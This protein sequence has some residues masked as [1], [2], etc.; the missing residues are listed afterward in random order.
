[1]DIYFTED[2]RRNARA[3]VLEELF[4]QTFEEGNSNVTDAFF[5]NVPYDKEKYET[6]KNLL[7]DNIPYIDSLIAK[8]AKERPISDI[9]GIDLNILRIVIAEG[10]IG[11]ITPPKVAINEAVELAKAFGAES[12]YKFINGVLGAL[13]ASEFADLETNEQPSTGA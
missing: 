2:P 4:A 13:Y 11:K 10:F 5:E 3:L 6:I 1:M 8:Y 7:K 12:S 9:N